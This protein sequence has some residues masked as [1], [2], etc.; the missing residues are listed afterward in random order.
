MCQSK[1]FIKKTSET[2]AEVLETYG[3]AKII[4]PFIFSPI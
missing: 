4:L 1:Y 2:Y 3:L